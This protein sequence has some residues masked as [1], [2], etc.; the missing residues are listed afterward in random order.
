MGLA[1]LAFCLWPTL[2]WHDSVILY[3]VYFFASVKTFV[4]QTAGLVIKEV[5]TD[6]PSPVLS[7]G[8]NRPRLSPG[9]GRSS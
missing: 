6:S 5:Q 3:E 2:S 1:R 9:Q 7:F 4:V 8:D